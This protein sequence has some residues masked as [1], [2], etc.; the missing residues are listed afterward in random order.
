MTVRGPRQPTA[1]GEVSVQVD[2]AKVILKDTIQTFVEPANRARLQQAVDEANQ[3]P[4]EQQAMARMQKLIPL[5][6]EI[7]GSK[8][9]QHGL[10][11]VM[12][13]VMQLQQ[14]AAQ[15]PL[16]AEGVRIL[17]SASMGNPVDDNLV[18]SACIARQRV[19]S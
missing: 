11:N 1:C 13:G 10:P 2:R 3:S 15:D 16:V 7:A 8:L 17:T 12:F 19:V 4:P 6:T 9:Q 5:V 14:V 18:V